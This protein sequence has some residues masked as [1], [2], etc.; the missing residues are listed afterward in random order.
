MVPPDALGWY[1]H[2]YHRTGGLSRGSPVIWPQITRASGNP[3]PDGG[4]YVTFSL[5]TAQTGGTAIWSESQPVQVSGGL[6]VATM[7]SVNPLPPVVFQ[8]PTWLEISVNGSVIAPRT[9]M[10]SA[11]YAMHAVLAD[12]VPDGSITTAKIAASA[13]NQYQLANGS[14]TLDKI[15]PQAIS[16]IASQA[17]LYYS[18]KDY[19]AKGDGLTDDTAAIQ[20]AFDAAATRNWGEQWPGGSYYTSNATVFFPNGKYLVSDTIRLTCPHILGDGTPIIYQTSPD[21][22]IFYGD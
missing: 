11:P 7:G 21:K 2:D 19:G 12:A 16:S 3:A 10:A 4:Y 18:V 15:A 1:L 13:V 5:F 14:V 9:Q 22:D 17:K 6:F 20:A 8:N